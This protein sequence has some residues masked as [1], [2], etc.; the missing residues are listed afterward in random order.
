MS[1]I[2]L[3]RELYTP[4]DRV[5]RPV[6]RIEDGLV[7]S[8]SSAEAAEIPSGHRVVDLGDAVLVPGFIDMHI[9]GGA[10]RDVMETDSGALPTV[11]RF[12]F[13]HGVTTYFPTTITASVE[14][15]LAALE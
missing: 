2:L 3:A 11:E 4:V 9:H 8:I 12:L 10:G 15:T 7:G 1:L 13:A 5:D 14:R 6:V